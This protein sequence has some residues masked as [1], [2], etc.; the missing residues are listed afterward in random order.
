MPDIFE[1]AASVK[2]VIDNA[3][4]TLKTKFTDASVDAFLSHKD[5]MDWGIDFLQD[6][7]DVAMNNDHANKHDVTCVTLR[8]IPG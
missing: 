8:R 5:V 7:V 2:K 6:Q 1:V 4:S 3:E